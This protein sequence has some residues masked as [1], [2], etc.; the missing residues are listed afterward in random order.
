MSFFGLSL[1][2][3]I[4]WLFLAAVAVLVADRITR[5]A[6][7]GCARQP[8]SSPGTGVRRMFSSSA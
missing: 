8:G 1:V 7:H 6:L 5:D 2:R 4:R 3:D